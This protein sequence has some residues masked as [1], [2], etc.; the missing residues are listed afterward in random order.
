MINK[1]KSQIS[2]RLSNSLMKEL[3]AHIQQTGISQTEIVVS[4]L[5]NYLGSAEDTSVIHRL[6]ILEK[7][8]IMLECKAKKDD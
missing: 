4:A 8:I 1:K 6:S 3:E 5:A 7:R 2:F